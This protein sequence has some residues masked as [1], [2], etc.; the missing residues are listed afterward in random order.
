MTA[1]KSRYER[2]RHF[3]LADFANANDLSI[4]SKTS[5][6]LLLLTLLWLPIPQAGKMPG[7]LSAL[8]VFAVVILLLAAYARASA[9][10]KKERPM[11]AYL[12]GSSG[13]WALVWLSFSFAVCAHIFFIPKLI[14]IQA[15]F[16]EEVWAALSATGNSVEVVLPSL[17]VWVFFTC[18]WIVAW[19]TSWL[20]QR[21]ICQ[22]LFVV[23]LA[24]LFQASYGLWFF[25][26]DGTSVL[27]LWDKQYYLGDATGTF[28]NR[29]HFSGMLAICWPLVLSGLFAR[30]PLLFAQ[31]SL[32]SRA[33]IAAVY[34]LLVI[35]ALVSAHSRMG[36]FAAFIGLATWGYVFVRSQPVGSTSLPRWL[37]YLVATISLVAAI[38]FGAGDILER[39]IALESGD[40]RIGIWSAIFHLPVNAWLFG[41][42]PGNFED[43]FRLVQPAYMKTRT[44]HA[45]NDYI[46]FLLEFGIIL[47]ALIAVCAAYS[48]WRLFPRG[49]LGLR[50]GALGSVTAIALHSTLDFNLQV[51]GAAIFFW[52]AIG[53]LFN[54]ALVGNDVLESQVE[55]T[56]NDGPQKSKRTRRSRQSKQE[57]SNK[58]QRSKIPSTRQEW[59]ALFRSD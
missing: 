22:L 31:L 4:A 15:L 45:H 36:T 29:N 48:F 46:E 19:R 12:L 3:E 28:V 11:S 57:N 40:G 13:L 42:G 1:E 35:F 7:G 58:R 51:P 55:P 9:L 49:N 53:L 18:M 54:S 34:S 2:T 33:S 17:R 10:S 21:Q 8:S 27:G 56:E 5:F 30:K 26:S 25:L 59:L 39:Y 37:P 32:G 20:S 24:S 14:G 16:S 38:W 6:V 41:I 43:V 44:I 47:G 52:V 50:A 23:F